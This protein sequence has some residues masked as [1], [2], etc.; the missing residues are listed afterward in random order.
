FGEL[1]SIRL[2]PTSTDKTLEDTATSYRA[3]L[4]RQLKPASGGFVFD[5]VKATA[6]QASRGGPAAMFGWLFLG[7]SAF[8]IV[9]AL[10]LVGLLYRLTL[11]RRA[12]Q[13]GLLFAEGF[14]R[15]R[16]RWL[17]LGEGGVLALIG[18]VFG[19]LGAILYS[20]LLVQLLASLWPG[21]VLES[22]LKP[23]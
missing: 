6:S 22:F 23:H 4:K 12:S 18:A 17:L 13:I 10:L 14:T 11:D 8:L 19:G 15:A 2:A 20:R 1:T 9:A 7:F 21:G 3:A 16:V 5:P